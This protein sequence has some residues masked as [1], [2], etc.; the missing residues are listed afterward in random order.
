MSKQKKKKK[1]ALYKGVPV[2]RG[3][4]RGGFSKSNGTKL[5]LGYDSSAKKGFR[6][7]KTYWRKKTKLNQGE[8][9]V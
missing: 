2:G 8:F 5:F 1:S 4:K 6:K 9:K 7:K 3:R